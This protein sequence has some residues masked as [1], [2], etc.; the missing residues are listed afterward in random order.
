MKPL[1]WPKIVP[2]RFSFPQEIDR[3][4]GWGKLTRLSSRTATVLSLSRFSVGSSVILD[5]ELGSES[6]GFRSRVLGAGRDSFGYFTAQ[7]F[8][9]ESSDRRRLAVFL[10]DFIARASETI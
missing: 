5:W 2:A 6:F 8:F 1:S 9:T 4:A 3:A 7:L 10:L